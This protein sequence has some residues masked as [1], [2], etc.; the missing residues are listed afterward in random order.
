M[1]QPDYS[2]HQVCTQGGAMECFDAFVSY[3]SVDRPWVRDWLIPRLDR[4]GLRACVDYRDF[5]IGCAC[6]LNT[7]WAICNSTAI[8]LVITP[9]WVQSEWTNFEAALVQS[10]DP[11]GRKGRLLPLLKERCELPKRLKILTY[12]DF[13]ALPTIDTEWARLLSAI[14]AAKGERLPN[15]VIYNPETEPTTRTHAFIVVE[16]RGNIAGFDVQGQLRDVGI[17]DLV[18]V[19][20]KLRACSGDKELQIVSVRKG[21]ILLDITTTLSGYHRLHRLLLTR[22]LQVMTGI[23]IQAIGYVTVGR[24]AVIDAVSAKQ[25]WVPPRDNNLR[26]TVICRREQI[27]GFE[28]EYQKAR[29]VLPRETNDFTRCHIYVTA[30]DLSYYLHSNYL[31]PNSAASMKIATNASGDLFMI[32]YNLLEAGDTGEPPS[33]RLLRAHRESITYHIDKSLFLENGEWELDIQGAGQ[34][35]VV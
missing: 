4:A 16:I 27:N 30:R 34:V 9:H 2:A 19:L 13:T 23:P 21:S 11:L 10:E 14:E 29:M 33:S 24:D 1:Q 5:K 18:D 6:V 8:I 12:A 32:V 28:A 35:R 15:A 25:D 22:R 3:S 26:N 31:S 17:D 7:E 20:S